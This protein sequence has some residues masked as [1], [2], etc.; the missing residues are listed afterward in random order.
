MIRRFFNT[1]RWLGNTHSDFGGYYIRVLISGCKAAL[2]MGCAGGPSLEEA[3]K[4]YEVLARARSFPFT[5]I[6]A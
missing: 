5:I 2:G 1:L 4:D 6:G 3:R